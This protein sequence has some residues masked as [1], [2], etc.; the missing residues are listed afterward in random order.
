ML[1]AA[2]ES[3]YAAV[4]AAVAVSWSDLTTFSIRTIRR[5]VTPAAALKRAIAALA[6]RYS[7]PRVLSSASSAEILAAIA[8]ALCLSVV[9]EPVAAEEGA[10][11]NSTVEAETTKAIVR[12]TMRRRSAVVRRPAAG[13]GSGTKKR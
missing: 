3:T 4:A 1:V 11:A 5:L 9:V 12:R 6:L 7:S 2:P 13:Q 8:A 10:D